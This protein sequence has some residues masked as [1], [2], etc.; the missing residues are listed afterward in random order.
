M[1]ISIQP[2]CVNLSTNL[3]PTGRSNMKAQTASMRIMRQHA[4]LTSL[5]PE[6]EKCSGLAPPWTCVYV[7]VRARVC[8][9]MCVHACRDAGVVVPWCP[10]Q[11]P[12]KLIDMQM[13]KIH[14]IREDSD[15]VL[16]KSCRHFIVNMPS[17]SSHMRR[18]IHTCGTKCRS[19][20]TILHTHT[21]THTHTHDDEEECAIAALYPSLKTC[22]ETEEEE[23]PPWPIA[24]R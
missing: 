15:S 14:T 11:G 17:D 8:V 9:C 19:V 3:H 16:T 6:R 22:N 21:H 24:S 5:S 13:I 4:A 20:H 12:V 18:F 23:L 1:C 7:R 2:V 10:Q